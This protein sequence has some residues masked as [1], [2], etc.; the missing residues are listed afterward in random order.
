A[1]QPPGG[2]RPRLEPDQPGGEQQGEGDGDESAAA[3][4]GAGVGLVDG[5]GPRAAHAPASVG[6]RSAS[7]LASV[8]RSTSREPARTSDATPPTIAP[9]SLTRLPSTAATVAAASPALRVGWA[10]QSRC[11]G[12]RGPRAR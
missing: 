11:T 4:G 3:G 7:S 5:V 1:E 12:R 8:R 6:S 10:A 2:H 9:L